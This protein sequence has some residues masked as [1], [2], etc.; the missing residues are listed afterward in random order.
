MEIER[1]G[2]F[3][4]YEIV[5]D[6]RWTRLLGNAKD[7][8]TWANPGPGCKLGLIELFG[9]AE[10]PIEKMRYLLDEGTNK[11][12]CW[13]DNYPPLEMRDIEHTLCEYSKYERVSRGARPKRRYYKG[14]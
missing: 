3:I 5:T 8:M 7:I 6:L 4:A 2:H 11:S 1:V 12:E 9:D 14:V 10:R 13:P